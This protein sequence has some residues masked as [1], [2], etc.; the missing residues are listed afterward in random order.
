MAGIA[1]NASLKEINAYKK[2]LN[3][4]EVPA[5]YHMVSTSIGDLDGILTHGFDSAYKQILNKDTWNLNLLGGE[6]D[7]L[8]K[9]TVRY[10]PQISLRHAFTEM[11]YEL[12]C[13]PVVLGEKVNRT[14]V[15]NSNCPFKV[16]YPET[17]RMLFRINSLVSFIIFAHQSGD[18]A[19][20]ALLKYA[21]YR[22]EKLI[23]ILRESFEVVDVKG[24]TI[25]EFFKQVSKQIDIAS[26][27]DLLDK[28]EDN[29]ET[30]P[31]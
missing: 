21:F 31:V 27:E 8:G 12:H 5:I 15:N 29:S 23:S 20:L 25:A 14:L 11:G 10:K 13:Y 9:I 7:E 3:W 19:D 6:K 18:E 17:T 4:G 16:W 22:V 24:Y 28:P 1:N 2:K 26:Y 30:D